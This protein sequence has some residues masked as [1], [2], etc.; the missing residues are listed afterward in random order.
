MS[1]LDHFFYGQP[2]NFGTQ[3]FTII[4][5]GQT[6]QG[7]F[8]VIGPI[9]KAVIIQSA[10]S[11]WGGVLDNRTLKVSVFGYFESVTVS[12]ASTGSLIAYR[13]N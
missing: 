2:L 3:G 13:T 5:P 1:T 7:P 11:N 6:A 9:D 8:Y 4:D 10:T 12:S